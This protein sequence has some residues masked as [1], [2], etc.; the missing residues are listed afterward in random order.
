MNSSLRI[1][2]G[3]VALLLVP[4]LAWSTVVMLPIPQAWQHKD[5][6][7][8]CVAAPPAPPINAPHP[9]NDAPGCR[10]CG[11]YCAPASISMFAQYRGRTGVLTQQDN[12]YDWGKFLHGEIP[13]NGIIETT[14][15]GMYDVPIAM[16]G[17]GGEVQ[18][19]FSWSVANPYQ[20]GLVNFGGL[21]MTGVLV[22]LCIEDNIPILWCDHYNWPDGMEPEPDPANNEVTGHC[23]II[24]G[25]D[26]KDTADT[27]DDDYLIYDPWP[28]SGSPYWQA[29]NTVL[30]PLDVYLTDFDPVPN[31]QT[32]WGGMK[33]LYR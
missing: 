29:A 10:H 32:T 25:Y 8:P 2:T 7:M 22:I 5:T 15:V 31:D 26:D 19:A 23:K 30:S 24:A 11:Y 27:S 16:G 33:T 18:A 20:W 6:T 3:A 9:T 13:A 21:P 17:P 1:L 4:A 12:I 28:T 14:G